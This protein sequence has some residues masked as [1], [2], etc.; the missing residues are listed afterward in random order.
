[1][2][3]VAAGAQSPVSAGADQ[4]LALNLPLKPTGL[5]PLGGAGG[6][7]A[8]SY[9][10]ALSRGSELQNLKAI[11]DKFQRYLTLL[12]HDL[13]AK[14]NGLTKKEVDEYTFLKV[15]MGNSFT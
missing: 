10:K 6:A 3:R 13:C 4:S 2:Q 7:G 12:Y 1:M 8:V 15:R 14:T 9:Q 11:R 5:N